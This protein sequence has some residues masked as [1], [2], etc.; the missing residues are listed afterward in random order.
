MEKHLDPL[1]DESFLLHIYT[2]A[3]HKRW[4]LENWPA[5]DLWAYCGIIKE[6]K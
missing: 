6:E 5:E 4:R 3:A 2:E 1:V